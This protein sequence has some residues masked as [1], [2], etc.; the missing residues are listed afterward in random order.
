MITQRVGRSLPVSRPSGAGRKRRRLAPAWTVTQRLGSLNLRFVRR[1]LH[2]SL[3]AGII[4]VALMVGL[5]TAA[6]AASAAAPAATVPPAAT[7]A[8]SPPAAAWSPSP[9]AASSSFQAERT[10]Q[11]VEIVGDRTQKSSTFATPNGQFKTV[12]GAGAINYQDPQ[13]AWEPIN[14]T[15]E[16]DQTTGYA[17][18]NSANRYQAEFPTTLAAA[19]VKV[20]VGSAWV[21]YSL[22]GA[23]GSLS[24]AADT[25]T[26]TNAL[27]GVNVQY[28]A[29]A[30][31]VKETLVLASAAAPASYSF[32]VTASN[33][34][35][36]TSNGNQITASVAGSL[37]AVIPA[38]T[39]SD[40]AQTTGPVSMSVAPAGASWTVTVTPDASWLAAPSRVFPVVVEPTVA[41]TDTANCFILQGV[42]SAGCSEVTVQQ[43][44]ASNPLGRGLVSFALPSSVPYDS[45]VT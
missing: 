34:V 2:R 28:Q 4:A 7:P 31:S 45:V 5:L 40:A 42:A 22:N 8:S 37:V 23:T 30:D 26:Y 27:P 35:T 3:W 9:A 41:L 1:S 13:G 15:L 39:M 36:L 20:S 19:P 6:P 12:V 25:A 43:G 44:Y 11:P 32:T 24:S 16:A 14:N 38:P 10:G 21:A 29:Q 18:Q 33:G 17:L